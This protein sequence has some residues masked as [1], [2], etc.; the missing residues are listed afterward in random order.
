MRQRSFSSHSL[1]LLSFPATDYRKCLDKHYRFFFSST[2]VKRRTLGAR[3]QRDRAAFHLHSSAIRAR[4]KK[5][6]EQLDANSN[7]RYLILLN[8]AFSLLLLL[9]LHFRLLA[10]HWLKILSCAFKAN[11]TAKYH[12][13]F[14]VCAAA[15]FRSSRKKMR[16]ERRRQDFPFEDTFESFVDDEFQVQEK[17][18]YVREEEEEEGEN[19]TCYQWEQIR[20]NDSLVACTSTFQ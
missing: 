3:N 4:G 7:G 17:N 14:L 10:S 20:R 16:A 8:F 5:T 15:S 6:Q 19:V 12:S 18:K 13:F 1:A 9:R 2:V 11:R